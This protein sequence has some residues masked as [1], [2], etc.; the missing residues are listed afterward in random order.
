MHEMKR[1]LWNVIGL[2]EVPWKNF[3]ETSTPE[4]HRLFFSGRQ[5]RYEHEIE[6]L[7]HKD[8]E[9][10][11][12]GCRPVSSRL[13]TIRLKASPLNTTIIQAY[14]PTTDYDDD[15]IEDF[16]DQLQE[17]IHHVPKKTFL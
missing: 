14:A 12:M 3:G 4:C 16:C 9:N 5:D 11:I 17:V 15:D 10:V 7:I 6:F 1:Y 8:T 13:I 2:C